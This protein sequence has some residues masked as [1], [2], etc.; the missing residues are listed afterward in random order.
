VKDDAAPSAPPPSLDLDWIETFTVF[1][2]Q[3]NLTRAARA[4]HLSQPAVHAHIKRLSEALGVSLYRRA[5]RRLELTAEGREVARFGRETRERTAELSELLRAGA[6]R[7]P[8]TL[9]AGE[10]VYL[11][12]IGEAV[13]AFARRGEAPLRLL[14]RDSAGTLEAVATGVAHVGVAALD[15]PPE[16]LA[17]AHLTD[18]EQVVVVPR[19]HRIARRRRVRIEDLA[20]ERLIVPPRD[21]PHRIALEHALGA[22]SVPW[23]VAVEAGGWELMLRFAQLG[24][25]VAVVNGCCRIPAGLVARP[26]PALPRVRYYLVAPVG[27]ARGAGAAGLWRVLAEKASAWRRAGCGELA[28]TGASRPMAP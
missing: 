19:G 4:R 22:A 17:H 28:G 2:E 16:A 20:G 14:T 21:R 27:G 6:S 26:L 5:G 25:G 1:A 18:V 3:M 9:C 7:R 15:A 12:L 11:Y 13:R 23:E 8:V 24:L 10:G